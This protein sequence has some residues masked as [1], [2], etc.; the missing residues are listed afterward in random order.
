MKQSYSSARKKECSRIGEQLLICRLSLSSLW[1]A[2][3]QRGVSPHS[4][5]K[6]AML[7]SAFPSVSRLDRRSKLKVEGCG[8]SQGA[9]HCHLAEPNELLVPIRALR[10]YRF[11][12]IIT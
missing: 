12:D 3:S 5:R 10:W 2:A 11:A 4:R 7:A 8:T 9:V 6:P 1:L